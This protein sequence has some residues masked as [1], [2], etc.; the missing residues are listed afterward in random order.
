LR[1]FVFIVGPAVDS[2]GGLF[3][4]EADL[5]LEIGDL[6]LRGEE[7]NLGLFEGWEADAEAALGTAL[8]C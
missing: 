7:G 3:V 5:G 1:K 4:Q 8:C 2:A 6:F